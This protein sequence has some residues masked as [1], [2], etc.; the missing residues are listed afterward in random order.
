MMVMASQLQLILLDRGT[1]SAAAASM[2]S[3]YAAGIVIGRLCC[4]LALDRFPT[5]MM[6]A[7]SLGLP[8][9]GLFIL[10]SGVHHIALL[11][12]AVLT[13]GL[14]MGAELDALAYLVMRYFKVEVWRG[15]RLVQP[16]IALS[17]ALGALLLSVTLKMTGGFGLFLYLAGAA[18]FVGCT[19]FLMLGRVDV[20]ADRSGPMAEAAC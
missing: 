17:S 2:V 1:T 18:T 13:V 9:I 6:S 19:F 5:H 4:G 11:G 3:L 20:V 12:T 8:C 15:I 16:T 14:S 10:A 7:I